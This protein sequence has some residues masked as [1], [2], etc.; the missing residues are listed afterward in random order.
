MP[1]WTFDAGGFFRPGESQY[2]DPA[3]HER[4]LR[5][6]QFATFS[7]L[8]RVHGYQTSTEPWNFG[9]D[10]ETEQRKYLELRYKLLP[11]IYS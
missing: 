2:K 6:L 9:D 3:Y 10:V 8:Q 4:F 5:W 11:Y 1:Y 7:P